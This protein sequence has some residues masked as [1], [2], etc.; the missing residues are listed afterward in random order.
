MATIVIIGTHP[1]MLLNFRGDLLRDLV[2]K[3]HLVIVL[4]ASATVETKALIELMGATHR[5][6]LVER[7]G[8]NPIADL[9]TF[10]DLRRQI[11]L[12]KPDVVLAYTIKPVIWGGLALRASRC[13]SGFV[14]LITGTGMAMQLGGT[15]QNLL[16]LVVHSLYRAA[17]K[18]AQS[19]IFQNID[20][21]NEFIKTGIVEAAKA[22]V[23]D[24]SGVNLAE[25]K[26]SHLPAPN[27]FVFL[28]IARLLRAKGLFELAR[29][30]EIV[31][32]RYPDVI[33]RLVGPTDSSRDRVSSEALEAWGKQKLIEY[34]GPVSDVRE[35]LSKAHV[36]VLPSYHEG[37]PRAVLEAMATGRAI[38]TTNAP[39]CRETVEEGS[40]GFLVPVGD[41]VV[42]AER[43]LWLIQNQDVC[44][45]MGERSRRISAERFDV[46]RI[47]KEM[48][49]IIEDQVVSY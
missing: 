22:Y 46:V 19:I 6:F 3:K 16:R 1:E 39:G 37:L 4:T 14:C 31:K 30:A 41:H 40:N 32:Q 12:I 35:F 44:A 29:A 7:N 13:R 21:K 23:V 34:C 38:V 11:K 15:R 5:S 18:R 2:E 9:R 17:L 27:P 42:L 24:G 48:V 47:N 25:F 10:F 33:F 43:M 49:K 45:R 26:F 8:L 28:T 36:F 20:N